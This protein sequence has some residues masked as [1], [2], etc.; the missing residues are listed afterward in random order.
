MFVGKGIGGLVLFVLLNGASTIAIAKDASDATRY[1]I[2]RDGTEVTDL[3]TKLVWRRCAEGMRLEGSQ[4]RG[5]SG[6]EQFGD[7]FTQRAAIRQA[8]EE[9]QRTGTAWRVPTSGE[10]RTLADFKDFRVARQN[11]DINK[12]VFPGTPLGPFMTSSQNG[13][14]EW[15]VIAR[16]GDDVVTLSRSGRAYLR[17]VRDAAPTTGNG[18]DASSGN[19]GA[20]DKQIPVRFRGGWASQSDCKNMADGKS[21]G[22][23]ATVVRVNESGFST[24]T[25]QCRLKEIAGYGHAGDN[26]VASFDCQAGS[27]AGTAIFGFQVGG[28]Q[29]RLQAKVG[30]DFKFTEP[31]NSCKW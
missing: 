15:N 10:M 2:S 20:S 5:M 13:S 23:G 31:L 24:G 16:N 12:S 14:G 19:G 7:D 3:D 18:G 8:K 30:D 17:L 9:S 1:A 27:T 29:F 11:S 25:M 6:Q 21:L 22:N 4:C 26:M 28:D